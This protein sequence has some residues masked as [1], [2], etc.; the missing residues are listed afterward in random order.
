M[1][2][3]KWFLIIAVSPFIIYGAIY[4]FAWFNPKLQVNNINSFL[5]YDSNNTL[6]SSNSWIDYE[7]IKT[8][9]INATISIEDKNFFN[10]QGFDYLRIASATV[11]N[12]KNGE[13]SQG[14]ST[15]TQQYAKNLFL[16]FDKTMIRKL[17]EAWLAIRIE[18]HYTKE[19]IFEGYVNSINYGNVFGI[20]NASVYYF[21]KSTTELTLAE[22]AML[23]GIPNN[24]SK[25][26]PFNDEQAAKDRQLIVLQAM[27]KN[28]YITEQQLKEAYEETLIYN[29]DK[30]KN[31]NTIM[32]FKDYAIEELKAIE[33]IPLSL[34]ESGQLKIYT[35]LDQQAQNA[36]ETTLL[37][38][39]NEDTELQFSSI[40]IEPTTGKILAMTGGKNYYE[41]QYNRAITETRS[42]GST[43][44]P[45]LYYTA[46]ESGFT[47]STNFTSEQTTFV[48]NE[49][50][51]YSPTNFNN[52]YPNQSISLASAI[53]HSD[54]IFAVKTH[55]FLGEENLVDMMQRVGVDTNLASVPSLALGS[56]P[57]SLLEMTE[58]YA[59]LAN[60]GIKK[61]NYTI[62]K[63]EDINGNILYE[64]KDYEEQVLNKSITFILN[65]LLANSTNTNFIDYAYPTGYEI[66][67]E[68]TNKYAI[69]TGTTDYDHLVFGY[70]K[71]VVVGVW[72]GYD[73][74]RE[75]EHEETRINKHIWAS[76]TEKYL[77]DKEGTW[78]D[79][80]KNVVGVISE[81]ITGTLA[82]EQSE[83]SVLLYY[84][85]GTE[86]TSTNLEDS[87]PTI[88]LE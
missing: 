35:T 29:T 6:I 49:D 87:I 59:V 51:T 67:D 45:F 25:Y 62:T 1:K 61:D 40:I 39:Y 81:P 64:H 72:T 63:V 8:D 26:S 41:S 83:K 21:N 16:D 12:I 5:F 13:L 77:Q 4:A 47:A 23:A 48:F 52:N 69:K 10:H 14:A 34:I 18:T 22:S 76:I 84:I 73:D 42:V 68:L 46:L 80:P 57:I 24:P 17:K 54:N 28:G 78:Y 50:E 60:E 58:S 85:K 30:N 65:E 74:N 9:F 19:E 36:I 20:E 27:Q 3:L 79:I 56:E 38:Y 2:K 15:I 70:N 7:N 32:Y 31:L 71:D 55:L 11:S 53:V 44:K 86:P 88:K 37:E 33:T 66:K 82:T 75:L 43:L